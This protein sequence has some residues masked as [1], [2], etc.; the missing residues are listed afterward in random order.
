MNVDEFW[1]KYADEPF[2]LLRGQVLPTLEKGELAE[3]IINRVVDNLA[4]V[5]DALD[6]EDIL[7]G[8]I[9]CALSPDTLLAADI[10]YI[11]EEKLAQITDPDSYVPFA[12]DFIIEI[13]AAISEEALLE[14]INLYLDAGTALIWAIFPEKQQ[15]V[16]YQADRSSETLTRSKTLDGGTVIKKLRLPVKALFPST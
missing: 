16:V 2:E 1:A 12:P 7:G 5:V 3:A 6:N 15:V 13:A 10:T 11:K 4:E 9:G 14:R 8:S